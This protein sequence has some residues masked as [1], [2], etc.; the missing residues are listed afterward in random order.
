MFVYGRRRHHPIIAVNMTSLIRLALLLG[1]LAIVL[2]LV[3]LHGLRAIVIFLALLVAWSFMR[4][5]AW[6]ATEGFLTRLTGSRRRAYAV[7]G[8]VFIGLVA[9][10]NIYQVFQ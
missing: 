9:A 6:R 10:V 3:L 7:A 1:V 8:F 2:T 4:T 5:R